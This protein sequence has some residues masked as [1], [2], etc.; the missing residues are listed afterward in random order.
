MA[1]GGATVATASVKAGVSVGLLGT[2]VIFTDPAYIGMAIAGAVM[3]ISSALHTIFSEKDISFA[4]H[5]ILAIST[6][7]FLLGVVSMPLL[8]LGI[9]EGL[10]LRLLSIEH[11][12]LSTS[13]SV[14]LA[15]AGSWYFIP[16]LDSIVNKFRSKQ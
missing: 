13:L 16:I 15:F 1:V 12:E 11:S 9:S 3:G 14:A 4:R 2:A 5:Q 6:K 8:F 7:S 10:F